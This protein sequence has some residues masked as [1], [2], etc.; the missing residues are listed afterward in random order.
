MS[1]KGDKK[2]NLFCNYDGCLI[3]KS[4][5]LFFLILLLLSMSTYVFAECIDKAK[6]M[7]RGILGGYGYNFPVSSGIFGGRNVNDDVKFFLLIPYIGKSLIEWER[8]KS[9]QFNAEGFVGYS[10]QQGS[11]DR[12]AMGLT[13]FF[14]FNMGSIGKVIP[15]IGIGSGILYTNLNPEGFGSHF[16]FTP[17]VGKG[18]GSHFNFTPQV[19]I[20]ISYEVS[21]E[22]LLIVSYRYHHISNAGTKSPNESID[23]NFF[24]VGLGVK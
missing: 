10:I 19:G 14:Q 22:K 1:K 18:F 11:L 15:F 12:Y 2:I 3:E 6:D 21:R 24:I 13:P 16:N 9:L 20:G 5:W 4:A 23:S 17:Q 7:E 8:C